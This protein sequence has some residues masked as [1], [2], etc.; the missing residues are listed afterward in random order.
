MRRQ[1]EES[2][3]GAV[4]DLTPE[5]VAAYLR[6]QQETLQRAAAFSAAFSDVFRRTAWA[7][8]NLDYTLKRPVGA[9]AK[10][11]WSD[12]WKPG[13]I[14]ARS[15]GVEVYKRE[16]MELRAGEGERSRGGIGRGPERRSLGRRVTVSGRRTVIGAG[17]GTG[18]GANGSGSRSR[19]VAVCRR[20][21]RRAL[22]PTG[23]TG[24]ILSVQATRFLSTPLAVSTAGRGASSE[25]LAFCGGP[26]CAPSSMSTVSTSTTER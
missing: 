6:L 5:K 7:T 3:A 19:A 14:G 10:Q 8:P 9:L 18:P 23:E 20:R 4:L 2:R 1:L 25:A 22:P 15:G 24:L 21:P 17:N 16:A 12:E 11:L 13:Q 26:G